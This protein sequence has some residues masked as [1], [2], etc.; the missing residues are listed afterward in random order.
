M[1]FLQR[2]PKLLRW[3][4]SVVIILLV[5]MTIFRFIFYWRYNPPGKAFSGS[6]FL[7]GLRFDARIACIVGL[8]MMLLTFI[9]VLNPFKN[10]GATKF[11]N[12]L[13]PLA[14]AI[15]VL[16][17]FIDF[18]HFDYLH[19][20]LNASVL[21][22]LQD[23]GISFS[24]MW[25]TYPL[26]KAAIVLIIL[27]VAARFLFG[28]LLA[29]YLHQDSFYKRRGVL[30]HVISFIVLAQIIVGKIVVRPGQFPLRWSDAFNLSD[31]FK[32]NLALNP[33]QSFFSTLSFRNSSFDIKKVKADYDLMATYLEVQK[34]DSSQLN[35]ERNY[36]T[37]DSA[38]NRPNVVLV[39]CESFSAYKSSMYG[40]PLNTTQFFNEISKNG[41]FFD[42]CFTPAYGTAR[43]VWATITGIPDVESPS[44]AS[45]NPNA[46]NQHTIINDFKGYNNYYFLGGSATWAN[47]RGL[48]TN[49]ISG[50]HLYEQGDYKA[51]DIDVWG[52]SDKNLFLEANKV[53]KEQTKPFF[54]VIQTAD[55]HR[56]YTIPKEDEGAFKKLSFSTDSLKRFGF[57]SNE[58][59]NAFR[60]TDFG[61]QQFIEAAK[62]E[63]Y[64][65][66]TIFVFVG[67]HG[68]RGS[69]GDMFPKS[70]TEQGLTCE[71][72]PLLFYAPKLLQPK[73][74]HDVC[75]QVDILPT[76]ASLAKTPYRN[77]TFG[78]DLF[79]SI[80]AF[81]GWKVV[82]K[83]KFAFIIDHD[84]KT[85]G[86]ISNQY[87]FLK[88]IK[89]GKEDFVSMLNNN[90][91]EKN[92]QTDSTRNYLSRLTDAYY[93]TAKYLMLNNKKK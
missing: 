53:L 90:P 10:N 61:Y 50:V 68:I 89:T 75:S 17:Y 39:I 34:P 27:L 59:M 93:E 81:Q 74:V 55:N 1:L 67:D 45:R 30:L 15:V 11:W 46:V 91:V 31:D 54:A 5:T 92:P 28:R 4:F 78:R 73:R 25:Q 8:A 71:H 44:T 84:V 85:I 12:F 41:V 57:E 32:S 36:S 20:R 33:F 26:V 63:K 87:Y 58:E 38:A 80:P 40:N 72:V 51:S 70:W 29:S 56:P 24:M 14:F 9:P 22:Y 23:A 3:I 49:N 86:L 13:L 69:A 52:I 6:A 83:Q 76:V 79:D 42:R 60:Y 47:I 2:I 43:G 82:P 65:D 18:Y 7:M 66:N 62:K 16:F 19:Q 35:F 21:N 48:L 88:N 77:N 64:F 37:A